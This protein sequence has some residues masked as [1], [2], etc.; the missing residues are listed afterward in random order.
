MSGFGGLARLGAKDQSEAISKSPA[1]IKIAQ[2]GNPERWYFGPGR[3]Y[4][5]EFPVSLGSLYALDPGETYSVEFTFANEPSGR[6]LRAL[7][8][9]VSKNRLTTNGRFLVGRLTSNTLKVTTAD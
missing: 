5:G 9:I 6:E 1:S 7:Q 4:K 2:A 3:S 8:D